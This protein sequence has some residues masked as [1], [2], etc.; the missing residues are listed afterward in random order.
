M[1]GEKGFQKLADFECRFPYDSYG[2]DRAPFWPFLGEGF[3]GNIQQPLVLPAPLFYC[4]KSL[5]RLV[6]IL[7]HHAFKLITRMTSLSSSYLG[8]CSCSFQDSFPFPILQLQFPWS[9]NR[10]PVAV[11]GNSSPQEL[12]RMCCNDSYMIR[13]NGGRFFTY[14]WTFFAYS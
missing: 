6:S 11:T 9:S 1:P 13:C 8:D 12:S 2:R 5:A 10:L 4:W 3:R 14:S 7:V